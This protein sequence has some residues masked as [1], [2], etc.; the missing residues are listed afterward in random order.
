MGVG[1]FPSGDCMLLYWVRAFELFRAVP[2]QVIVTS[3]GKAQSNIQQTK[4]NR[5]EIA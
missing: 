2:M 4:D 5:N 1:Q 3:F